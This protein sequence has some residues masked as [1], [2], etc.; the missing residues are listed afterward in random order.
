MAQEKSKP[1]A[2]GASATPASGASAATTPAA[3]ETPKRTRLS[4]SKDKKL[5]Y[6]MAGLVTI[7]T[8]KAV[9]AVLTEEQKTKVAKAKAQADEI[10]GG[11]PFKPVHDR[12]QAIQKELSEINY[13]KDPAAG[14]AQAIELGKE[15]DRQIKRKKQIEEMI[16]G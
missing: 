3:A 15:L 5:A 10:G 14:A 12:I 2:A 7:L 11:D 13:M 1:A 16:G 6:L 9:A 4:F 8:S